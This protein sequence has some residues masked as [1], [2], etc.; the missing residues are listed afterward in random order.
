[1]TNQQQTLTVSELQEGVN[2]FKGDN[3]PNG[4]DS[5]TEVW[6]LGRNVL[7]GWKDSTHING[8][9]IVTID[10]SKVWFE[11]ISISELKEQSNQFINGKA[12][13]LSLLGTN[14]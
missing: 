11:R 5:L 14:C 7:E 2:I 8:D 12:Q 3:L 9:M 6:E 10:R 13:T 4:T 1:M